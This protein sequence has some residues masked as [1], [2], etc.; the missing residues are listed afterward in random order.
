MLNQI[1][2][3]YQDPHPLSSPPPSALTKKNEVFE[4]LDAVDNFSHRRAAAVGAELCLD[5]TDLVLHIAHLLLTQ[6]TRPRGIPIIIIVH[7]STTEL[8]A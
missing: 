1:N 5:V 6:R 2:A 4:L 7:M 3:C 8:K